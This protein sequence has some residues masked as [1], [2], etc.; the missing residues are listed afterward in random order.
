MTVPP[1]TQLIV[2]LTTIPNKFPHIYPTIDSLLSQTVPPQK[3]IVH[4]ARTYSLRFGGDPIPP[5]QLAQFCERYQSHPTV[6]IVLHQVDQDQGPGTKLLGLFQDQMVDFADDPTMTP[7]P[8]YIVLVDDDHIYHPTFLEGF[9]QSICDHQVLVASY[10]CYPLDD[11]TVGQGADGFLFYLPLVR[12][13]IT[14]YWSHI[15]TEDYVKYHDDVYIS[16][17]FHL[18]GIPI[19]HVPSP[20]IIYTFGPAAE[21]DALHSIP[22]EEKYTRH[23]LNQ[24]VPTILKR[25]R[26]QGKFD[27]ISI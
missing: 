15:H 7:S 4:F 26:A 3:I 24:Q 14:H 20:R 9:T 22:S 12:H 16:Y 6:D 21:T 2:S 27:G 8:T 5:E 19:Y 11:V 17:F 25:L 10:Y 1:P 23:R 18:L 13:F